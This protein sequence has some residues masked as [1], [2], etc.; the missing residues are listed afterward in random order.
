MKF[1]KD[2]CISIENIE[3]LKLLVSKFFCRVMANFKMRKGPS[4]AHDGS[5]MSTALCRANRV[6][7]VLIICHFSTR[8]VLP[9]T[10]V[11]IDFQPAFFMA[12]ECKS[13]I[14]S[15]ITNLP[16]TNN[17]PVHMPCCSHELESTA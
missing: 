8:V 11:F 10:S 3:L 7:V 12:A 16:F 6:H 17:M 1:N 4:H 15:A 5:R 14:S 2:I 13:P 9:L